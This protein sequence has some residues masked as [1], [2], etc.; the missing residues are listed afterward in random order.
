MTRRIC[1][2]AHWIHCRQL[3]LETI[4]MNQD[5][6]DE[7]GS[8]PNTPSS[9]RRGSTIQQPIPNPY[10]IL[11]PSRTRYSALIVTTTPSDKGIH[12]PNAVFP[13]EFSRKPVA[14]C[15]TRPPLCIAGVTIHDSMVPEWVPG[16]AYDLARGTERR[17]YSQT[18]FYFLTGANQGFLT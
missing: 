12:E 13:S 5:C 4:R 18:H 16:W 17:M 3:K 9:S 1:Q 14:A 10:S 6:S 2:T 7:H 11:S 8:N 15:P